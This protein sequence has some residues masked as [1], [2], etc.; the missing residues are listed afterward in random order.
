MCTWHTGV[1]DVV[2]TDDAVAD[3][4]VAVEVSIDIGISIGRVIV[5][6]RGVENSLRVR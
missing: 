2:E 4:V 1:I 5:G 3:D 6:N